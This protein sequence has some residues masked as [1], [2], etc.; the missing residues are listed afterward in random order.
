MRKF[1]LLSL[2]FGLLLFAITVCHTGVGDIL[3]TL[4]MF[5]ALIV[6]VVFLLLFIGVGVIAAWRWKI[7]I[8]T[9]NGCVTSFSK[10]L[11]ARLAAFAI[12][13]VTPAVL[14][15]GDPVR[16]YMT[17]GE[18][19]GSLAKSIASVIIDEAIYFFTLFLFVI[20]G[21]LFLIDSFSLPR[22]VL[23]SFGLFVV[24]GL[25]V[26]HLFYSRLVNK[27]LDADGFFIFVLKILK[28]DRLKLLRE[29]MKKLVEIEKIITEFF[30]NRKSAFIKAF[31]LSIL[32]VFMYL[33][34]ILVIVFHLGPAI[35]FIKS[36]SIFSILTLTSFVPIPGSFGSLEMAV[37]FIF[38]LME[39]GKSNGFA[40]SLIFRLVNVALVLIGFFVLICLELSVV[41]RGFD[42][43]A[44]KEL[45]NIHKF[46]LRL[47]YRK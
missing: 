11:A 20:A 34:M 36:I 25:I 44:P 17:R 2:I 15:G 42:F 16:A 24:F 8:E 29:K 14:V 39:L 1:V 5:P 47:I 27:R 33:A 22:G 38:S 21:F 43:E 6:F 37:T 46:I 32:E 26:L 19:G 35:S 18:N 30:K 40:F 4:S 7:I 3:R 45:T 12:S 9:Q 10:I 28:L 41:S 23:Y 31:F 13:Y